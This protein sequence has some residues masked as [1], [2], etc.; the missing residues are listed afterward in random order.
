REGDPAGL[1]E[2]VAGRLAA[3]RGPSIWAFVDALPT[4]P[5]GKRDREAARRLAEQSRGAVNREEIR[6]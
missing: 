3:A 6:A 1:A 5:N 2:H 4:T